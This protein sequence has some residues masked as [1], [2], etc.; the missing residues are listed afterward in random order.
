MTTNAAADDEV[1]LA[2]RCDRVCDR[3]EAAWKAGCRPRVEDHLESLPGTAQSELLRELIALD[4]YYRHRTGESCHA[5]EYLAR[6]PELELAWL[7]QMLAAPADAGLASTSAATSRVAGA[8]VSTVPV[9]NA[10][11][12][13]AQ[14]TAGP[15]LPPAYELLEEIARGGMGVVYKA[16]QRRPARIVALKMIL[17]DRLATAAEVRRF[18]TEAEN[19]ATLDHPH[20]V[21]IYEVGEHQGRPYYSMKLVEGGNLAEPRPLGSGQCSPLP[22]GRGS[23]G[24]RSLTD[25]A[26]MMVTVARAVHHAHQRGILHRDLKPA[27]IL[28]DAA[29]QP[30]VTDFGLATRLAG[31]GGLG[32]PGELVGTP[33][34]IAPEQVE[35]SPSV[36]TAVDVYSLGAIFYELLTGHRPFQGET[37]LDTLLQVVARDPTPP[38]TVNRRVDRDLDA[39]CLKCLAKDPE[40]RY[41]SAAALADDLE[42]WQGR[43]PVQARRGSLPERAHRWARRRPAV[44]ALVAVVLLGLGLGLGLAVRQWHQDQQARLERKV[45]D[46]A[47]LTSVLREFQSL[48]TTEVVDRLQ[49]QGIKVSHDYTT[50]DGTVPLPPTLTLDLARRVSASDA[51]VIRLYS[52][53][54][55]PWRK[56]RPPL[57]DFERQALRELRRQPGQ[58]FYRFEPWQGR[59]SLRYT[60]ADVMRARCLGC[61]NSDPSSPKRDWR[62]GDVRGVLEVILPLE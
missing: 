49:P 26:R 1:C 41:P 8:P 44:A 50:E 17:G 51:A 29:G 22:D 16:R 6:F 15:A 48:Y 38:R 59:R 46:A 39:I 5:E 62:E 3:F 21:P 24:K 23:D 40:A 27:N 57:D 61:H 19:A 42:R 4:V 9:E 7:R 56:D 34:Y 53:H 28:L 18:L 35:G 37:P 13:T 31:E 52:D 12:R 11:P 30:H 36:S 32:R 20:I 33:G 58:P 14:T 10:N 25:V 43:L 60:T 45:Q 47:M 54:P 2:R 55:F